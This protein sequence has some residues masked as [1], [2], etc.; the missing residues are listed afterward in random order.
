[1]DVLGKTVL[2]RQN[3]SGTIFDRYINKCDML[4]INR[5]KKTQY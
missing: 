4:V 3:G 5:P 1:M 2:P